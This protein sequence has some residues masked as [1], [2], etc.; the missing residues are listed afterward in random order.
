MADTIYDEIIK[1]ATLVKYAQYGS[2]VRE[3]I[4]KSLELSGKISEEAITVINELITKNPQPSEIVDARIN[5]KGVPFDT[6]RKLLIAEQLKV[7]GIMEQLDGTAKINELTSPQYLAHKGSSFLY[8]ENTLEAFKMSKMNGSLFIELDIRQDRSGALC[9]LHDE[10]VIRVTGINHKGSDKIKY[11]NTPYVRSMKVE[12]LLPNYP[13]QP[14]PYLEEV[15]QTFG[16]KINYA[17]ESKDRRS[18]AAIADL[19]EAYKL[20]DHV[21]IQSFN[22][23]E[24]IAIKDRGFELLLLSDNVSDPA[25]LLANN[26]EYV[27]CSTNVSDL[28]INLL[29]NAGIKVFVYTVNHQYLVKKYLD[30]G[31]FGIFS[32]DPFYISNNYPT[33]EDAPF[34]EIVFS[35]G[36]IPH[37]NSYR[38]GFTGDH[39][40]GFLEQSEDRD[41]VLQGWTGELPDSF[42]LTFNASFIERNNGWGSLAICTP[43][44]Y[45]DDNKSNLSNGYHLLFS[46]AGIYI[47]KIVGGAS[48]KLASSSNIDN[49]TDGATKYFTVIVNAT[50]ITFKTNDAT[51]T[52]NDSQFRNGFLHFGRKWGTVSFQNVLIS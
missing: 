19:A 21:L 52:V 26:I 30:L 39:K 18:A 5:Y 14:I 25:T 38:G 23:A 20:Q 15:F 29:K 42:T 36:F 16:N 8:P 37:Y 41:F 43:I 6:L 35:S 45:F 24:L 3:A 13:A 22:Q 46:P 28:Y 34:S 48:T 17:I 1:Y 10:D 49:M 40:W 47:Y 50:S 9:V 31:V 27:G 12:G 44:D 33:R 32:D 2:E 51:I 4:A 7:V 11:L